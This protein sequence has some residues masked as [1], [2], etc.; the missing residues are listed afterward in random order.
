MVDINDILR[1]L[2]HGRPD[3]RHPRRATSLREDLSVFL[4]R[5]VPETE[6]TK[7]TNRTESKSQIDTLVLSFLDDEG[8]GHS[9]WPRDPR[10]RNYNGLVYD[11]PANAIQIKTLLFDLLFKMNLNRVNVQAR[12]ST[13]QSVDP[14]AHGANASPTAETPPQ[15]S[16]ARS[17]TLIRCSI[18]PHEPVSPN[19]NA[20]VALMGPAQEVR[21]RDSRGLTPEARPLTEPTA[22]QTHTSFTGEDVPADNSD[23]RSGEESTSQTQ[24]QGRVAGSGLGRL[25]LSFTVRTWDV[26]ISAIL[27]FRLQEDHQRWKAKYLDFS[28]APAVDGDNGSEAVAE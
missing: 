20:P 6:M 8:K 27:K 13:N 2:I 11:D 9:H 14:A 23:V 16:K 26:E 18:E 10:E 28:K 21:S 22:Q 15:H 25:D 7:L 5:R 24:V 19:N 1:H 17:E 3:V 4:A 12:Q